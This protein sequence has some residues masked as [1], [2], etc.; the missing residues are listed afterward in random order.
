MSTNENNNDFHNTMND[1][2]DAQ[3]RA[4][5]TPTAAQ[6]PLDAQSAKP[7]AYDFAQRPQ[8]PMYTA[9]PVP[10]RNGGDAESDGNGTSGDANKSGGDG[11]DHEIYRREHT[12]RDE[13][14]DGE[15]VRSRRRSRLLGHG[16]LLRVGTW[17]RM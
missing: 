7:F 1:V 5:E 8:T 10:L 15:S 17:T 6:P 3:M 2:N 11:D 4:D 16:R 9:N 12:C 13:V 14:G